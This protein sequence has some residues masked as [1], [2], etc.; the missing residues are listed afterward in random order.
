MRGSMECSGRG[1]RRGFRRVCTVWFG[2]LCFCHW[3]WKNMT[4]VAAV[5]RKRD[6][7]DR[8]K[9]YIRTAW[10]QVYV[11]LASPAEHR[12]PHTPVSMVPRAADTHRKLGCVGLGLQEESE[13]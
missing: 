3:P 5:S 13:F 2:V 11:I 4:W 10:N 6:T 9:P 7:W 8:H 1:V 12:C